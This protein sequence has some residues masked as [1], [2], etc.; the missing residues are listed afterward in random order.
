MHNLRRI[1]SKYGVTS[2]HCG[3]INKVKLPRAAL[4]PGTKLNLVELINFHKNVELHTIVVVKY[5]VTLLGH[6][7]V[8]LPK[9]IIHLSW[10][11]KYQPINDRTSHT[12]INVPHWELNPDMV[13]PSQY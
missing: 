7:C 3:T 13:H 5:V 6:Y 4:C 9:L 10:E 11:K 2:H 12:K 1:K 8:Q